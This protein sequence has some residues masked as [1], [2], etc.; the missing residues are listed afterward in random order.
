MHHDLSTWDVFGFNDEQAYESIENIKHFVSLHAVLLLYRDDIGRCKN[1]I[2][3][4]RAAD[5]KVIVVRHVGASGA[6]GDSGS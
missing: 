4:F 5:V 2:K 3:L 1:T 6:A